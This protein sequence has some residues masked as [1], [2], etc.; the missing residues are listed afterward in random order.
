MEYEEIPDHGSESNNVEE[1]MDFEVRT[2]TKRQRELMEKGSEDQGKRHRVN[3][4]CGTYI[5]DGQQQQQ[6]NASS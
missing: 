1:E 6:R 5:E 4:D 3:M 2:S